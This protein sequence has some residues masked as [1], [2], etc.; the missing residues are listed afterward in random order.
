MQLEFTGKHTNI[1]ITD[2]KLIV[3]EA[4]R[5]IDEFS[6]S[7]VVKVGE[8]LEEVPKQSFV[9]KIEKIEDLETLL[10]ET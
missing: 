6:S 8:L 2:D 3:L 4:L 10:Y 9:P 1:V 7:R 5:H